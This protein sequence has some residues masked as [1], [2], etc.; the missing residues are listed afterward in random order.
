[1]PEASETANHQ[2]T[3]VRMPVLYATEPQTLPKVMAGIDIADV[4]DYKV[5]KTAN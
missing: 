1:M 3:M 4:F 2:D 5:V